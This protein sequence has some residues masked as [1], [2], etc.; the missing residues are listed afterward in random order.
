MSLFGPVRIAVTRVPVGWAEADALWREAVCGRNGVDVMTV[1][2]FLNE[3]H[4]PWAVEGLATRTVA[5]ERGCGHQEQLELK[6]STSVEEFIG[7]Q[8]SKCTRCQQKADARF[9]DAAAQARVRAREADLPALVAVSVRQEDFALCVRDK[10]LLRFLRAHDFIAV[11]RAVRDA[12]WWI[13]NRS[14]MAHLKVFSDMARQLD[15][16]GPND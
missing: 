3:C 7:L 14:R 1:E 9:K 6:F 12:T 8:R 2:T 16:A 15:E 5:V 13:D 4:W 11:A 10:A